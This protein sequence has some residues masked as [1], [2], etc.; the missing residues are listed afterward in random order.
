MKASDLIIKKRDGHRL[1]TAEIRFLVDGYVRGDIPDYQMAAFLMAVYFR[2]MDRQETADLTMAMVE[3]GEQ[4]NL[5]GVPGVKVDKHS[6]GGVGDKTTLVLVPLVAA[7]GLPV[8]KMSGRALG[9]TGGTLDKLEAIPGFRTEL[10]PSEFTGQLASVGAVIA[11]QSLDLAPADKALY[12]LRDVTGTVESI[13]LIASSVMSKKIASGADALVLDVKAGKGAFM[14]SGDEAREL[15]EAMIG[16]AQ[17]AGRRAVAWVTAMDQP[18]GRAVGNALEVAE[19]IETLKGEG[20]EDLVQLVL[21][22]GGEMLYLGGVVDTPQE[23]VHRVR[24]ALEDGSALDKFK[25]VIEAQGGDPR[26]V[27][28]RE[29]LP[30]APAQLA[31][32]APAAGWIAEIDGLAVGMATMAL[33]AGRA[34]KD[35]PVDF[36]VGVVL[37]KKVGERVE[38]GESLATVHAAS[39]EEA[40]AAAQ[41]IASAFVVAQD[42]VQA[43]QLLY[44]RLEA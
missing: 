4:V 31:V 16:I 8:A 11:G 17:A 40:Q 1:S 12:A 24:Q 19:A 38:R 15:A 37:A 28:N 14:K 30:A 32:P 36:R 9:H 33:G 26:V 6:T 34:V 22:L 43:P 42:P 3:S 5:A 44:Q 41:A 10:S 35:A 13:P 25:Q 20:P 23:G 7:C 2:G 18:L 21:A 27:E 29:L 39:F